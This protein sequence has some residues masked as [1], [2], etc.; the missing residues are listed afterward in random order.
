MSVAGW[1]VKGLIRRR[2]PIDGEICPCPPGDTPGDCGAP[3][4]PRPVRN[5]AEL[6]GEADL[7]SR[8]VSASDKLCAI[9]TSPPSATPAEALAEALA[10]LTP[11]ELACLGIV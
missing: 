6:A 9:A 8:L 10:G 4:R 3:V 5:L 7:E 1:R 2:C 11:Y